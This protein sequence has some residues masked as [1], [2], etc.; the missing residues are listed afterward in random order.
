MVEMP[1]TEIFDEVGRVLGTLA[2]HRLLRDDAHFASLL[3]DLIGLEDL[4]LLNERV[5]ALET[6][7]KQVASAHGVEGADTLASL[8]STPLSFNEMPDHMR[9][10]DEDIATRTRLQMR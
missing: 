9:E 6:Y 10:F 4:D 7:V 2:G 3:E 8:A 5:I 1:K